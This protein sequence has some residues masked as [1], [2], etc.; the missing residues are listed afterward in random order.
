MRLLILISISFLYT[1]NFAQN[2]GLPTYDPKLKAQED[3]LELIAKNIIEGENEYERAKAC[4]SFIPRLVKALKLKGSFQYPF[5]DLKTISIQYPPDS[6]FRIFTWVLEKNNKTYRFYGAI[7]M[8][9][10]EDA[11]KLYPLYDYSD[12]IQNPLDAELTNE[13]WYGA[14]YYRILQVEHRKTKYYTLLG[15]DGNTAMSTKKIADVLYFEDDKPIFGA[16]IFEI[17]EEGA[18]ETVIK[19]RMILE[20]KVNSGVSMN[21]YPP[22]DMIIHD[23]V[24]APDEKSKGLQFTYVP[25]G[26]YVGY[27]WKKGI[28][29]YHDRVFNQNINEADNPPVPSPSKEKGLSAP[30]K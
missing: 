15:W 14:L 16:P 27:K 4:F 1:N 9:T 5:K 12:S 19:N 28:W 17:K 11:L 24:I 13:S 8:N 29:S 20:Y 7:Q 2:I 22:E 23:F 21:Y 30:D 3:S 25:D 10:G 6:S 18:E 26:T